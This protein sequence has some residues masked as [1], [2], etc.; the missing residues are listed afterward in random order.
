MALAHGGRLQVP[1]VEYASGDLTEAKFYAGQG[2]A[3]EFA[4]FPYLNHGPFIQA[5]ADRFFDKGPL[6]ETLWTAMVWMHAETTFDEIRFF[7]G[8]TALE[9]IIESQLGERRGTIIPK[10][11]F[12]PL[13]S[14][15]DQVI[16]GADGLSKEAMAILKGRIAG[17]NSK[18]FGEKIDA[19]FDE[20]GISRA[21]FDGPTIVGLVRL[22]NEIVHRGTIPGDSSIWPQIILVRELITRILLSEIG[23]VGHYDCYISERHMRAFPECVP[24]SD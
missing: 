3:A 12:A 23:F 17:I 10:Q 21:D 5:L 16:D 15:I 24:I 22:R 19:L 2:S 6:P 14:A 7:T 13:R 11:T 20:Y 8:M 18:S 1:I 9:A 4:V